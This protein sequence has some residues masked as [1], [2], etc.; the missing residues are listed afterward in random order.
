MSTAVT[1]NPQSIS[2][3]YKEGTSDKEYHLEILGDEASGFRVQYRYGRRGAKLQVR[4][5][6]PN[7]I[8]F[9]AACK[10]FEQMRDAQL[11]DGYTYGES[12]TPYEHTENAGKSAGVRPMLLTEIDEAEALKLIDDDDWVMQEKMNGVRQMIMKKKKSIEGVNKK[13]LLTSLPKTTSDSVAVICGEADAIL[14]GELVG[15]VLHVFDLLSVGIHAYADK[16]YTERL[17]GIREWLCLEYPHTLGEWWNYVRSVPTAVGKSSKKAMF[18][19]LKKE[20]AE[21][22]VFKK[23]DSPYKAGR[24]DDALKFKF[25]AEATV[26]C[27]HLN[28]KNSFTMEMMKKGDWI[29]VG[30]CTFFPT[31][32]IPT[33]GKFYEI[34]YLYAHQGGSLFQ[35]F[36]KE[37]RIDVDEEDCLLIQLK[38]KPES[39]EDDDDSPS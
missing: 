22:V 8:E 17:N 32:L 7:P 21:G 6:N 36:L 4:F 9:S 16:P 39:H 27:K 24:S 5:K 20:N 30:S 28:D 2:L 26:R 1:P 15:E 3:Y 12:G 19:R 25:T 29:E 38:Y 18:A 13:G 37:E 34:R 11:K 31:K 33:I 14:D 23:K 35:P 10:L